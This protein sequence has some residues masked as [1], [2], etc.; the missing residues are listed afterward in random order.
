[1]NIFEV[2][3]DEYIGDC[4][5]VKNS[6]GELVLAKITRVDVF[7]SNKHG[8][9]NV[10]TEYVDATYTCFNLYL[11]QSSH[12]ITS[13]LPPAFLSKGDYYEYQGVISNEF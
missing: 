5:W 9:I 12:H 8:E 11:G 13:N 10:H 2:I 7:C 4:V 6:K 1:M 3:R